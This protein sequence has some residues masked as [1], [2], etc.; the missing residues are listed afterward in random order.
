MFDFDFI[1][2][3]GEIYD[4]I[5]ENFIRGDVVVKDGKVCVVG[6]NIKG[7]VD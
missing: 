2:C 3:N 4:G 6:L 1:I 5:G 7:I